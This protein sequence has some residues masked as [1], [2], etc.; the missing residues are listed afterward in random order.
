MKGAQTKRRRKRNNR[1]TYLAV[2]CISEDGEI[3][4]RQIEV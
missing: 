2:N 4:K 3:L 1:S